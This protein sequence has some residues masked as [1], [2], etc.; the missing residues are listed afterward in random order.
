MTSSL[1]IK[2]CGDHEPFGNVGQLAT[3]GIANNDLGKALRWIM[4]VAHPRYPSF[5]AA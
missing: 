4:L 2:V 5:S 3:N 1:R